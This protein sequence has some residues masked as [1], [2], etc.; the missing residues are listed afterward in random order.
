M[1]ELNKELLI[2]LNSFL[3]YQIVEKIT[4]IF[5]DIPI[6]FLPIFLIV[7]WLYYTFSPKYRSDED[8][9]KSNLKEKTIKK[10]KNLLFIFYS[11][12]IAIAINL[13]IQNLVKIDRPETALQ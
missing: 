12:V 7:T 10:K 2:Y 4:L 6:F 11:C 13:V 3:N 8:Q 9:K 1:Q 5:A